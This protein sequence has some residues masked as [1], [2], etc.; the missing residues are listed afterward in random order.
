MN[1]PV[2]DWISDAIAIPWYPDGQGG[3]VAPSPMNGDPAEFDIPCGWRWKSPTLTFSFGDVS[4][5]FRPSRESVLDEIW[6]VVGAVSRAH[7]AI[8]GVEG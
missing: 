6:V 8:Y 5:S 4:M 3:A 7:A 2:P 1:A